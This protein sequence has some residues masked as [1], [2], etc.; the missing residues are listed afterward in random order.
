LRSVRPFNAY[1]PPVVP[2]RWR[3]PVRL[4]DGSDF[5]VTSA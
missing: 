2:S 4:A 1:F 5:F 3:F